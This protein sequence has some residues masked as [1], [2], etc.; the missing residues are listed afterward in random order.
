MAYADVPPVADDPATPTVDEGLLSVQRAE[1]ATVCLINET[2]RG[3][4]LDEVNPDSRLAGA[5]RQHAKN[6][7]RTDPADRHAGQIDLVVASEYRYQ[8]YSEIVM[9]ARAQD[10]GPYCTGPNG[11]KD[12]TPREMMKAW[13]CSPPH[14]AAITNPSYKDVGLGVAIGFAPDSSCRVDTTC[15]KSDQGVG[16]EVTPPATFAGVF[17][18]PS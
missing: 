5:A 4:H 7:V 10:G 6:I 18:I 2:R 13:Q 16:A 17:A 8:R 14:W 15:E 12:T 1:D 9:S 11:S 3:L